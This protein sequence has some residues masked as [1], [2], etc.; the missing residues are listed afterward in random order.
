MPNIGLDPIQGF[1]VDVTVST[2]RGQSVLVGKFTSILVRVVNVT[3]TYLELNQRIPRHLD[4]EI[5]IVW[6]MERGMLNTGVLEESFGFFGSGGGLGSQGRISRYGASGA[7]GYQRIPRARR[8]TIAFSVL[9]NNA[10]DFSDDSTA[11]YN[12]QYVTKPATKQYILQMCKVDTLSFGATS[13]R[14][15]VANQWQGTAE[16][17]E[18]RPL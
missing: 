5:N 11:A 2:Y 14:N 4:G 17:I 16:G 15:I 1:D 9:S 13:G 12:D 6:Q 3:E 10:S 18:L 7:E 8:F